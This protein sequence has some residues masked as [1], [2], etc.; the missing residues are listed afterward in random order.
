MY[1]GVSL[2]LFSSFLS[3]LNIS[4]N[5]SHSSFSQQTEIPTYLNKLRKYN[6]KGRRSQTQ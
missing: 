3:S 1:M 2:L 5:Q 6:F 4:I